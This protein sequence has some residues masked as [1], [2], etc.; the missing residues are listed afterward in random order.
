MSLNIF[1]LQLQL[2]FENDRWSFYLQ[3]EVYEIEPFDLL[4]NFFFCLLIVIREPRQL[5]ESFGYCYH[6]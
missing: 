5:I 6:F 2:A 4:E 1:F 3:F